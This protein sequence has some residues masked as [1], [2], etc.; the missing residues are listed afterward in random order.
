MRVIE[1]GKLFKL[2]AKTIVNEIASS[3]KALI[4]KRKLFKL[5]AMTIAGE[6]ASSL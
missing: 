2:L 6:I 1:K 5:L 3:L 4:K